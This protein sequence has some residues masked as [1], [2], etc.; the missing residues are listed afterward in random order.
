MLTRNGALVSVL[1]AIL[2]LP[3]PSRAE[4]QCAGVSGPPPA[5]AGEI[6]YLR[7]VH[8]AAKLTGWNQGPNL[9][10]EEAGQPRGAT[11][12]GAPVGQARPTL[13]EGSPHRLRL[14]L[15]GEDS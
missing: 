6:L 15:G 14:G 4:F 1:C 9:G 7:I 10:F 5:V 2:S 8:F 13:L 12:A 11:C 3:T